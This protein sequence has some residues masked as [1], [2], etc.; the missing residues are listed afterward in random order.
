VLVA[1]G[2]PASFLG[3]WC[4]VVAEA[5]GGFYTLVVGG[6][7]VW[8]LDIRWRWRRWIGVILVVRPLASSPIGE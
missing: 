1:G 6:I 5:I 3:Q 2:L 7:G 4:L 8:Y